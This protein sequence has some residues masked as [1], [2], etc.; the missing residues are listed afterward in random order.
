MFTIRRPDPTGCVSCPCCGLPVEI[1]EGSGKCGTCLTEVELQAAPPRRRGH[2]ED[3]EST[4][5]A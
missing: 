5:L 4:T 1:G 2:V 3:P